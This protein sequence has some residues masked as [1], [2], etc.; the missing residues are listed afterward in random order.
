MQ[1]IP[2]A[3]LKLSGTWVYTANEMKSM[4]GK[5]DFSKYLLDTNGAGSTEHYR[6][7]ATYIAEHVKAYFDIPSEV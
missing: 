2:P 5:K 3:K 7:K 1:Q 4:L 6:G